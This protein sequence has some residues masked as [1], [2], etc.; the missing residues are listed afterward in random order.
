MK[1]ESGERK[2]L[3]RDRINS[4]AGMT[5][6]SLA[7]AAALC[8]CA[9]RIL[10]AAPANDN[11]VNAALLSGT[12]VTVA[13]STVGATKEVG[14]P[15]HA[16]NTGGNSIWWK[17]TP[18]SAG[19]VIIQTTGSD[20]DTLLAAYVGSSLGTLAAVAD[21]DDNGATSTSLIGF[22][23][24]PGTTY[25]IAV[26]GYN[27]DSGS[28]QLSLAYRT[29]PLDRPANDNFANR[30]A[31]TGPT[32]SASGG[33]FLASKERGEPDHADELGGASVW[34]SWTAPAPG[35]VVIQ[36][37]G[38][39]FDTLLAVY[40][41]STLTNLTVVA[42][43]DDISTNQPTSFV[44]FS[45]IPNTAYQIAVDGYD[46]EPGDIQLHVTMQDVV[47]LD[48]PQ[49]LVDGT[50]KLKFSG[51]AGKQNAIEASADLAKWDRLATVLN[52]KGVVE[53]T[54]LT[55]VT[56]VRRFYRVQQLP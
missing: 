18:V 26:D 13:G 33:N 17:W 2:L 36:T 5:L 48:A 38:S 11:F 44:T 15:N 35:N 19:S 3:V 55:A 32:V 1:P 21:N 30:I 41:G 7:I 23:V 43:S 4:L 12:N 8:G 45:A 34:W 47:W 54:D 31:L 29:T 53:Y 52:V 6:R 10:A 24:S 37:E 56:A 46:G 39:N 51:A 16:A 28:I 27:G 49:R 20:A 9:T 42:S 40:T 14:E 22:N 25:F 50:V